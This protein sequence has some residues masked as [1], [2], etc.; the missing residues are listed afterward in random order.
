[1]PKLPTDFYGSFP[2]GIY[3]Q[4]EKNRIIILSKKVDPFL[5]VCWDFNHVSIG[6]RGSRVAAATKKS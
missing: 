5:G 6:R 2:L 4:A 3:F 1:M